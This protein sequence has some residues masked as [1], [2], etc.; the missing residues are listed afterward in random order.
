MCGIFGYVSFCNE[1]V[2]R[3]RFEKS[4]LTMIH[5]GP[6]FQSS[7]FFENDTVALG[8]VRLSIIDLSSQANQP[9]SVG[10]KY[11]V[12]FNGEIYNY[13]ELKQELELKGYHFTTHS[14]T[15]VLVMAY[16]CWGEECVHRFNG[17]W[18]F[19]IYNTQNHTL[20]CSRDR[21]GVKPFNYYLDDKRFM[22]ASEIKPL[23]AYDPS[24]RRPNYNSIGLFCREGINGEIP[25][26]WF[27]G[28][29]RLSPGH[30]LTI[31][32]NRV[33]IYRYYEYPNHT[34]PIS[35][36]DAKEQFLALFIDA[37]KLRMR[38]DVPVGLT[39]SGGL[40][41]TAIAGV[42]RQFHSAQLNTY[43]ARFPGFVDD[44]YPTAEK[45]NQ[46]YHLKGHSVVI[47]Y[48]HGYMA[49]LQNIIYYL[50]SGH[51]SS[52]I[53]PLWKVY[54]A[55]SKDVTVVLE[56]QGAD[57]LLAGYIQSFA[58]PSVLDLLKKGRLIAAF[59]SLRKLSHNYSVKAIIVLY[60]RLCLP[61]FAKTLVRRYLL[62]N[63]GILI[64]PLKAFRYTYQPECRSSS[65]LKRTLQW[66]HQTTL[67][68]LLHY[69]DAISMAF[70][71]ESRLPFMDYRLVNLAMSL[72]AD[73]LVAEGKGKFICRE[74]LKEI[75]PPE[76]FSSINKLGFPSPIED[77]FI[78]NKLLLETEL[79]GQRSMDRGI[80]D[81]QKLARYIDN[82]LDAVKSRFLFRLFCVELWFRTF[83]DETIKL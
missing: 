21:F 17:M 65:Y 67:A 12:I 69:G 31:K 35:F 15:E 68:N 32:N 4:L 6:D 10:G 16:D 46:Y 23:I 51:L 70:S 76:I 55:A 7:L 47:P 44:E 71:M 37:C 9:M 60:L 33:A 77:F 79:L 19:A 56:G 64:G 18:G 54:E 42:V 14:D 38:S 34:Q 63:E 25:E 73:Y 58:M 5:R 43:T 41:S 26:T 24:L 49:T 80:F 11:S 2:N 52:A 48:D 45:T 53:F 8:H 75:L 1:Q 59:N 81:I 61:A 3:S 62:K 72:P 22:F 66:S 39:L 30:N 20:F 83:I 36:E 28:I 50:E 82:G 57:E 29:Y 40:D 27:E 74:A 78:Q 13:I